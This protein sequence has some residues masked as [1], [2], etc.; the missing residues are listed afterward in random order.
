[1]THHK[2]MIRLDLVLDE[3]Y[4]WWCDEWNTFLIVRHRNQ[5]WYMCFW[6]CRRLAIQKFA[7]MEHYQPRKRMPRTCCPRAV[8]NLDTWIIYSLDDR[9]SMKLPRIWDERPFN[10]TTLTLLP[11]HRV[12]FT[13]WTVLILVMASSRQWY[14]PQLF[15]ELRNREWD[16]K[17]LKWVYHVTAPTSVVSMR[18]N[19]H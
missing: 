4:S 8:A 17:Q 10:L 11:K 9:S 1:M 15:M 18:G 13:R 5:D 16:Y 6:M 14:L 7:Q 3:T 12:R 19:K 2:L